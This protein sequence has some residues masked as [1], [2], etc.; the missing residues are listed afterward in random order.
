MCF[1][2]NKV[3]V[4]VDPQD[5]P[6]IEKDK[7]LIKYQLD[8]PHAYWIH[9]QSLRPLPEKGGCKPQS[10]DKKPSPSPPQKKKTM[11]GK[12]IDPLADDKETIHVYT[13][14]ASSGNPGPAGIGIYLQY[15]MHEK[16]ISQYIGVAT[17]NIAE[18]EAIRVGLAEIKNTELPVRVYTD[19]SYALGLLTLGWKPKKN[20]DIVKSIK[21]VM[22]KFKDLTFVKVQGHNG[23]RGNETADQLATGAIKKRS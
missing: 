11:S 13:D 16:E 2:H 4:A 12:S 17:N 9:P 6:R 7:V 10:S 1:K 18:L 21:K 15:G 5:R 22:G 19:S 23:N 8:Q 14:G 20:Q 3:W